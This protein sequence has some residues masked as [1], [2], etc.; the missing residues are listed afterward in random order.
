VVS[1]DTTNNAL[2]LGVDIG[3]TKVAAG[4]VDASGEIICKGRAPMNARGTAEEGLA[5]V[6]AAMDDAIKAGRAA[7]PNLEIAGIGIC[8]PGPLDPRTGVV[9]NPPNLPCWRNF[10]LA[11]EVSRRRGVRVLVENDANA[12][13]LAEFLWGAGTGYQIVF[14]ATLGTGIGTGLVLDGRIYNGRTGSA[15]EGGHVTI[16][17]H[18][19]R[20]GCGK[21][22]CIE[23]LAS[24]PAIAARAQAAV[25]KAGARGAKLIELAGGK[26]D[27]IHSEHV[28]AAWRAGDPL[29][30]EILS[31]TMDL[32][33][34]WLGSII[35][36]LEPEV[37]VFGGGIG[38][39][40]SEWFG[41]IRSKLPAWCIIKRGVEIPLVLARYVADSGIA[42]AAALCLAPA[43]AKA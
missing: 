20:C 15:T 43:A 13:G 5:S 39:L 3:G 11:D 17:F 16:D 10:P 2:F 7:R 21:H 38:E 37:I 23:A 8:S 19:P 4:L 42:G 26:V 24:G 40:A 35:D 1:R 9:I 6:F 29:A 34:T 14:Y 32:L 18:G 33:T 22:G 25:A 31:E 27:A 36:L 12:A 30:T 41:H 28:A